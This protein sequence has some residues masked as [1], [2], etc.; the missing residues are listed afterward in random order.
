[1]IYRNYTALRGDTIKIPLL[2]PLPSGSTVRVHLRQ[3]P[4][5]A[6]F[7]SL[8]IIGSD[9]I[10]PVNISSTCLGSYCFDVEFIDA[11]GAVETVQRCDITFEEDITRT[12]GTEGPTLESDFECKTIIAKNF[13]ARN[14]DNEIVEIPTD[15]LIN[16]SS[17]VEVAVASA[18]I[19]TTQAGIATTKAG[20]AAA[21]AAAALVSKNST[22]G[23]KSDVTQLK[24]DTS[25]LKDTATTQAGIATTKASEAASSAA[26]ALV[27]KN[28]TDG[29]KA[30]VTQL[31]AD[32]STLKDTATTQAGIATTKAGEASDSAAAALASKNS[33]DGLKADVTQLKADTST[34]KDTATTQAGIATTK[35]GE[36]SDS[37]AAAL[38]S[39]NSTDGLKS[40]VT[41]LKAD[42]STLKDTA[43]TQAGIATT[44]AGEAAASAVTATTQAGISTTKASE[45]SA[46]AATAALTKQQV[47]DL[48]AAIVPTSMTLSYPSRITNRNNA[49]RNILST[50]AP[51]GAAR[52]VLFLGDD[53]AVTVFPDGGFVINRAG[54]SKIH[55][56]PTE[57]TS[58]Y[59]TIT[60]DVV[61]P[62]MRK[63]TATSLRFLANGKIRL[64]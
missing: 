46:S 18:D 15:G 44:K 9:I 27:S 48:L 7:Q 47:I 56:I 35:A 1:M 52:N 14:P 37:A 19:A 64:T 63:V 38:A 2:L 34:L 29:L 16:V 5:S 21:S 55:C 60:I 20:E 10:I 17:Y 32:T 6:S 30:D 28:S 33:T 59:K 51:S 40:D 8:L 23:L 45:A 54:Q 58:L 22:D 53:L 26:A 61:E 24:A 42:T 50:M 13:Y 12:A 25:T 3:T 41:Q 57:N 62:V 4:S 11:T 31:K 36:A 39:K 43:T 49:I